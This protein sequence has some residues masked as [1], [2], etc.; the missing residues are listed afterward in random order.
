MKTILV[1]TDFSTTSENAARYAVRFAGQM[2]AQVILLH[3]YSVP[4]SAFHVPMELVPESEIKSECITQL[5]KLAAILKKEDTAGVPITTASIKGFGSD[6][7]I[8]FA[9]RAKAGFIIMGTHGANAAFMRLFG[10][11]TTGVLRDSTVP[12][13]AIPAKA[14]YNQVQNVLVTCEQAASFTDPVLDTLH[15]LSKDL[16]AKLN[17]VKIFSLS[18]AMLYG[19]DLPGIDIVE[20]KLADVPH[21]YSSEIMTE[22]VDGI[23]K[24]AE[25]FQADIIVVMP[26]KKD[27]FT[28]LF[29]GSTT[30]EIMSSAQKPILILPGKQQP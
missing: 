6:P 25:K 16:N 29:K 11:T 12:V 7:I 28:K 15:S 10:N 30:R 20:Q 27:F 1:P 22:A 19:T 8:N 13:M 23:N 4:T 17:I 5:E 24:A 9:K 26:L 18:Q 3:V 14:A 2:R 21:V